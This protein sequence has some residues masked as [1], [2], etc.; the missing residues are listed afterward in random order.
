MRGQASGVPLQQEFALLCTLRHGLNATAQEYYS[1][2]E[3]LRLI[4]VH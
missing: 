1:R 2:A 4:G 3:A